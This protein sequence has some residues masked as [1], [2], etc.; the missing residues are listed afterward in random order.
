MIDITKTYRTR[1]G[2]EVTNLRSGFS[3]P[4]PL[5]ADVGTC[6]YSYTS[7]GNYRNDGDEDFKDLIL[8]DEQP[9][10]AAPPVDSEAHRQA[11]SEALGHAVRLPGARSAAHI[12]KDAEAF[13]GFLTGAAAA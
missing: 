4:Y 2:R 10:P 5:R 11:R 1:D 7:S 9:A 3:Y 12:V 6:T 8:V 13:Y